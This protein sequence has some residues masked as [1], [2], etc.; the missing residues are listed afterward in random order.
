M[1]KGVDKRG[2]FCYINQA[3]RK[4]GARKGRG[5]GSAVVTEAEAGVS[6]TEKRL[7]RS[8]KVLD[9]ADELW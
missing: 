2:V 3:L 4:S 8:K 6:G 9:K 5:R 1:K 7:E